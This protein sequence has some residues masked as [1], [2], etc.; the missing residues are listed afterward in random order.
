MKQGCCKDVQ[1]WAQQHETAC[2]PVWSALWGLLDTLKV[3]IR[4]LSADIS[5]LSS[6]GREPGGTSGKTEG[7][8]T[9]QKTQRLEH[10]EKS[11]F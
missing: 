1:L 2:G 9:K 7:K 4:N 8:T 5:V 3:L 6:G 11:L 10:Q